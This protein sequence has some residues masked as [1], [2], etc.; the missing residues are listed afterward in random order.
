MRRIEAITGE[1][2]YAKAR[3]DEQSVRKLAELLR[4]S[5]DKIVDRVTSAQEEITNL[6]NELK[7]VRKKLAEGASETMASES[8]DD[9]GMII[10]TVA[11]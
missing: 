6:R 7:Q 8:L 4:T 2:A 1:A 3:A 9:L 11:R 5:P 10:I